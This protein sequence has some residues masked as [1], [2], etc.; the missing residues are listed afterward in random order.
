MRYVKKTVSI[1]M[2]ICVC[3]SLLSAVCSAVEE[4]SARTITCQSNNVRFRRSIDDL[5]DESEII[6]H[7]MKG[8]QF[9][10]STA[11]GAK[12]YYGTPG[13]ATAIYKKFGAVNGYVASGAFNLY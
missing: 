1:V 12:F 2:V 10:T 8:D 11:E 9:H 6:G 3:L 7:L 4:R 13:S 5:S